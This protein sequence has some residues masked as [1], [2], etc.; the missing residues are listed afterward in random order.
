MINQNGIMVQIGI[1]SFFGGD[2]FD[3]SPAGFTRVTSFLDFI[4]D[5]S[6]IVIDP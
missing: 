2:F 3:G 1:T 4:E 6:N 5:N